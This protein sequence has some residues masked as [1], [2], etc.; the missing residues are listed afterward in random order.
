MIQ[1]TK[2]DSAFEA[3][4]A[5]D[6]DD[7]SQS[8]EE[9]CERF[10]PARRRAL[11]MLD[12]LVNRLPVADQL[13]AGAGVVPINVAE[14]LGECGNLL[15]FR[16]YLAGDEGAFNRLH[17]ARFCQQHLVCPFC[18]I[19]RG[20]RMNR[21]YAPVI[22][23]LVRQK[24]LK[25][26]LGTWTIANGPDLDERFE[27]LASCW[28]YALTRRRHRLSYERGGRKKLCERNEL[29][30]CPGLAYSI[31]VKRGHNSGEWH[32]HLHAVLLASSELDVD[33]A[34]DQWH[35]ITG[36][37][38]MVDFRPFRCSGQLM[39]AE[40]PQDVVALL[41]GDL[42]EVLK[43]AVK[44]SSME[45][46]DTWQAYRLL[47]GRRLIGKVGDLRGLE[48]PEDLTDAPLELD[49]VPFVEAVARY[50]T[51]E[52]RYTIERMV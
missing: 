14:R 46:A 7:I 20:A 11:E 44:F 3:T 37:S 49:E 31:E 45:L 34:R 48:V 32:P 35:R 1:D 27:H 28:R 24:Q 15:I 8:V 51:G 39:A 30:K 40:A 17:A 13:D 42:V 50:V 47:R 21:T 23:A 10:G 16:E 19:R 25:P 38:F 18:A 43:Y 36:D 6:L 52:G 2:A 9:R 26:Y 41:S 29:A 5:A 22:A 33:A 12:Y 4:R